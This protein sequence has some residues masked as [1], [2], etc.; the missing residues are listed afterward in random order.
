MESNDLYSIMLQVTDEQSLY[1]PLNPEDEFSAGV[2]QYIRS[3]A[4][5]INKKQS[6]KLVVI[7]PD[8]LNQERFKSAVMNWIH[9]EKTRFRQETDR[10]YFVQVRMLI[11]G[12]LFILL[13]SFWKN[14]IG[15]ESLMHIVISAIGSFGL[16][17]AVAAW[18]ER[19]PENTMT[20][21]LI[22]EMEA[23]SLIEF[24]TGE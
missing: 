17:R 2:K 6:L 20:L 23:T 1:Q 8:A 11:T 24:K 13:G 16:G 4:V 15:D 21:R 5:C 18:I 19:L 3:K 14:H 22:N 9:E 10:N 12:I 7:S